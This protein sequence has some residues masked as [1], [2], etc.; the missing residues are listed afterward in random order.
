MVS[1]GFQCSA[2]PGIGVSSNSDLSGKGGRKRTGSDS[3]SPDILGSCSM[4]RGQ[5]LF[6]TGREKD[7][8]TRGMKNALFAIIFSDDGC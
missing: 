6:S 3:F 7:Y 4:D 5:V 2:V 1:K 8:N